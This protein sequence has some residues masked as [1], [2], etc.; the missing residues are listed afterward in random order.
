MTSILGTGS[1]ASGLAG[2]FTCNIMAKRKSGHARATKLTLLPELG[3]TTQTDCWGWS[4]A[5]AGS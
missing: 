3:V 4:A 5:C 2:S 1:N